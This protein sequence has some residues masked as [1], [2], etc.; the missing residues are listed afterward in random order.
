MASRD[1]SA[2]L[3]FENTFRFTSNLKEA[4]NQIVDSLKSAQ[5]EFDNRIERDIRQ[6]EAKN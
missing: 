2:R 1:G 3:E 5:G 6:L 4:A